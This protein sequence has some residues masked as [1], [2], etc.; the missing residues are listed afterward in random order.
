MNESIMLYPSLSCLPGVR[1]SDS[2]DM[3]E[4][5]WIRQGTAGHREPYLWGLASL[6]HSSV[7]GLSAST[8]VCLQSELPLPCRRRLITVQRTLR[9]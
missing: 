9:I 8:C 1:A 5:A 4:H 2:G 3:V 6:T 7:G